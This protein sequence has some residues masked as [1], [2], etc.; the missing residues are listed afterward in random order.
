MRRKFPWQKI[1]Q[2][3]IFLVKTH[4]TI[5]IILLIKYRRKSNNINK[6]LK[7]CHWL[8]KENKSHKT[9]N[10]NQ[11]EI[12]NNSKSRSL[13]VNPKYQK[14][15]NQ[16]ITRKIPKPTIPIKRKNMLMFIKGLTEI[17]SSS[18]KGNWPNVQPYLSM[19]LQN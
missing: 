1:C 8:L 3:T 12:S 9:I 15:R 16:I 4:W 5:L 13:N 11:I 10:P 14:L 19:I 2:N 18:W 7:K 6:P 17:W